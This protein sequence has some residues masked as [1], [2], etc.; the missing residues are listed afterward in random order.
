MAIPLHHG[1]PTRIGPY[2][3]HGRLGGGGM[4]QVFLGRSPG[5]RLVAVKVV[6]PELAQDPD[7]RRRFADEV[8]AARKVGGF[9]TAHI[10]DADTGADPP[11]MVTAYIAGPSLQQAVDQHGP[12]PPESVAVLGAGLA[13]GLMAVHAQ[14]LVHRD[15]KPGNVLLAGDGPRLIDFGIARATDSLTYTAAQPVIGTVGYMS[16]E[17]AGGSEVAPPSDVF[18]LGCV[19]AFA[20]TGRN[21]FGSGP[22]HAVLYR[23]VHEEPDLSRLH[24]PLGGLV[25]SCLAKSPSAR[26]GLEKVLSALAGET[27]SARPRTGGEW[28]PQGLTEII[29]RH[30]GTAATLAAT[31]RDPETD[32]AGSQVRRLPSRSDPGGGQPDKGGLVIGNLGPGPLEVLADGS[33]LGSVAP[34]GSAR[35]SLAAGQHSVQVRAAGHESAVRRV[36]L[37]IGTTSRMLFDVFHGR[38]PVPEPV[39]HV[40][41]HGRRGWDAVTSGLGVAFMGACIVALLVMVPLELTG[42]FD[43][44]GWPPPLA[45]V[46]LPTAAAGLGLGIATWL[47]TPPDVLLTLDSRGVTLASDNGKAKKVGWEDIDQVSVIGDGPRADIVLWPAEAGLGLRGRHVQG[48]V[49]VYQAKHIGGHGE[50]RLERLRAALRWFAGDTYVEQSP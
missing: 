43:R 29:T 11:W 37:R 17:Q 50:G 44:P 1:D 10:V 28:L 14:R 47:R 13:E 5:S 25:A 7:F 8:R 40:S 49:S 24:G 9:Y 41:F 19:L 46:L 12:L 6:R 16:P 26:P 22:V 38:G 4:G 35:F 45:W 2:R 20:A 42:Q 48:G 27:P 31:T 15:L 3:I 39:Q 18:A 21:P 30:T 23:I 34:S 36:D 33:V 32:L